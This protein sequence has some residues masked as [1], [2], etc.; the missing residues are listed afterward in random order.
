[1]SYFSMTCAIAQPQL[2]IFLNQ[3]PFNILDTAASTELVVKRRRDEQVTFIMAG[4]IPIHLMLHHSS[5]TKHIYT[6]DTPLKSG[7]ICGTPVKRENSIFS[8]ALGEHQK[9]SF[10][11]CCPKRNLCL[12]T[13]PNLQSPWEGK[14][15][16]PARHWGHSN[17]LSHTFI[18]LHY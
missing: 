12:F 4:F 5:E 13:R 8:T 7:H 9:F 1:M 3:S 6:K 10:Y 18:H 11:V 17:F 16:F 15:L 14:T 2:V